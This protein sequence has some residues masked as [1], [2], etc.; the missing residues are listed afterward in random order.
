MPCCCINVYSEWWVNERTNKN[1]AACGRLCVRMAQ[2][3]KDDKQKMRNVNG[4]LDCNGLTRVYINK[5]IFFCLFFRT[6][7]LD[8][9]FLVSS[10]DQSGFLL[11]LFIQFL[12]RMCGFCLFSFSL[13]FFYTVLLC[14]LRL[15]TRECRTACLV[16][17]IDFIY[18]GRSVSS[19]KGGAF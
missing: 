15:V 18:C 13:V 16:E 1:D 3:K 11:V 9:I 4:I 2:Y 12:Y 19:P 6:L 8:G 17:S 10:T 14:D 7:N 5:F